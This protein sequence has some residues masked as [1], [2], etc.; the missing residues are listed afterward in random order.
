M[1]VTKMYD[2]SS[3][4]CVIKKYDKSRRMCVIKMFRVNLVLVN[5]RTEQYM[6]YRVKT[7]WVLGQ[8]VLHANGLR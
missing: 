5:G 3:R 8:R 7:L 2:K 6:Q 4:M 1:C